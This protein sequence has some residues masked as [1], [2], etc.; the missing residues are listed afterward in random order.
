MVKGAQLLMNM[1]ARD[2]E[3]A[4]MDR[5]Y[6]LR[7]GLTADMSGLT[8]SDKFAK[9]AAEQGYKFE[10]VKGGIEIKSATGSVLKTLKG[11]FTEDSKKQIDDK[12][13]PHKAAIT[14]EQTKKEN[15]T[16][17]NARARAEALQK[18][19]LAELAEKKAKADAEAKA[20]TEK[21]DT[22]TKNSG[23]S[24]QQKD[25]TLTITRGQEGS[26]KPF[27]ITHPLSTRPTE[28]GFRFTAKDGTKSEVII[29]AASVKHVDISGKPNQT[30]H[31][32]FDSHLGDISFTVN[33]EDDEDSAVYHKG[34]KVNRLGAKGKTVE[35]KF[36]QWNGFG[37]KKN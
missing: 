31:T 3:T 18:A 24:I 6:I 37:S 25:E 36:F 4:A 32:T 14:V 16:E 11:T 5:A 22:F 12:V 19:Y 34:T 29:P 2:A 28:I 1:N 26:L 20:Q 13:A 9:Q 10:L 8:I 27:V 33:T 35:T 21:V 23:V 17:A 7:N 15:T 30:D